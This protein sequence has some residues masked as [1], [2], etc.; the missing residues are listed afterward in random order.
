MG[1]ATPTIRSLWTAVLPL[2][3]APL[4]L[5]GLAAVVGVYK[6]A[7]PSITDPYAGNIYWEPSLKEPFGRTGTCFFTAYRIVNE[8]SQSTEKPVKFDFQIYKP[9]GVCLRPTRLSKVHRPKRLRPVAGTEDPNIIVISSSEVETEF[10]VYTDRVALWSPDQGSEGWHRII[11]TLP[12]NIPT[13]DTV[14]IVMLYWSY[15]PTQTVEISLNALSINGVNYPDAASNR[16]AIAHRK[17]MVARERETLVLYWIF[18]VVLVALT[19]VAGAW[20]VRVY[21]R[22]RTELEQ[23]QEQARKWE[24]EQEKESELD[25]EFEMPKE[26]EGAMDGGKQT[27][28]EGEAH[29]SSA[30]RDKPVKKKKAKRR[31]NTE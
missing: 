20:V 16:K 18:F 2:V 19:L 8:S 30:K 9:A 14:D 27:P 22:R 23:L 13:G 11:A 5:A 29:E 15:S 7:F 1:K 3:L 25:K 4:I 21:T 24:T 31:R 17:E 6:L 12:V 28:P 10:E 26:D